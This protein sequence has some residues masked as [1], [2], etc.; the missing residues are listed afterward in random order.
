MPQAMARTLQRS[1]MLERSIITSFQLE[2]LRDAHQASRRV[3]L[4]A[5][6]VKSNVGIAGLCAIAGNAG[7]P[8][9]GLRSDRLDADTVA[10]VRAAGP[11][12]GAWAAMITPRLLRCSA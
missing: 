7:A 11:G 12:I 9:L 2:P 3:W 6:E 1:G 10:K 8:A 5:P 4:I